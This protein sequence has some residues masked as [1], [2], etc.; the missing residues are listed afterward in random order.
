MGAE[1]SGRP[2]S[3]PDVLVRRLTPAD[4]PLYR[5]LRLEALRLH[6]EAFASDFADESQLSTEAFA[7]RNPSPPSGLFGAFVGEERLVGMAGLVVPSRAKLRHK[8][9]LVGMYVAAPFRRAGVGRALGERVVAEARA[10]D[11]R[12]VQLGVTA[13]NEAARRLYVQLGFRC[14]GVEADAL[15]VD[16]V[17]HDDALMALWLS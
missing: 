1:P 4:A 7:A 17:F 13:T 2:V 10:A 11:L 5:P 6:P 14:Y 16:G 9:L 3:H 8:G 15:C 12:V